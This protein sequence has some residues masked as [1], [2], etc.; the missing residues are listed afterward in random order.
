MSV[1]FI[2]V[3][4]IVL[5]A[6]SLIS[7]PVAK[8]L[9]LPQTLILVVIGF[10]G[11]ELLVAN[12]IDT[13]IRAD[14]FQSLVLFVFLPVLTF[15]AA[16]VIN[17][18]ALL[19]QLFP[20]LT[21]AILGLLITTVF[22]AMGLYWGIGHPQ[23]F[24]FTSAL[25]AGVLLAAT[26]PVA[27]VSQLR[28]LGAPERLSL[29]VEGESLFND[30]AAIVLFSVLMSFA[31]TGIEPEV[32]ATALH[33]AKVF[34]GGILVGSLVGGLAI[35]LCRLVQAFAWQ[36][37]VM[38]LSAYGAFM[39][40]EA[41]LHVS[42][43]MSVLSA[44][45]LIGWRAQQGTH[46][47][48]LKQHWELIGHMAN[49]LLFLL[50]GVTITAAMF[51]ERYLAM[52]IGIACALLARAI[53]LSGSLGL[54]WLLRGPQIGIKQQT[55]MFW[56]GLRGAITLVLALAL[57]TSIEGWWTIQSI[58]YGLVLFTLLFQAPSMPWLLRRLGLSA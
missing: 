8:W 43:V 36:A 18:K 7:E 35:L 30:A 49:G 33:F 44:G 2:I 57:P 58:A 16:F 12:D 50:M 23:G 40:G 6:A 28:M 24:P 25:L 3:A 51:S 31:M 45:L 17:V 26:D 27:V 4:L 56:G 37:Q 42:G 5:L 14:S 52:L 29:L 39:L 54:V 13:G 20:I 21:V 41:V 19:R 15:E 22:I 55:V 10:I 53:A 46:F 11:S 32:S 1:E 48:E 47:P 34:F 38:L 9:R